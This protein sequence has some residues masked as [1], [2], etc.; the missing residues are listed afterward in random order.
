MRQFVE[1]Q[2]QTTQVRQRA[3]ETTLKLRNPVPSKRKCVQFSKLRHKRGHRD[4]PRI[5]E[6]NHN[7]GTSL[8][9]MG[10]TSIR[11]VTGSGE[12]E[13]GYGTAHLE[14]L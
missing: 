9:Q 7:L 1:Q 11:C 14:L 13:W 8:D 10:A 3:E 12:S 2:V 5:Q 6:T 4:D